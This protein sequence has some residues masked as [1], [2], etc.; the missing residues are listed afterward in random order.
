VWYHASV[1]CM[2]AV[3]SLGGG[4]LPDSACCCIQFGHTHLRQLPEVP[5]LHSA[6]TARARQPAQADP[7]EPTLHQGLGAE[8]AP[9]TETNVS[10]P[11]HASN[12]QLT[13]QKQAVILPCCLARLVPMGTSMTLFLPAQGCSRVSSLCG[14]CWY[15]VTADQWS[16]LP[17]A[18]KG[19]CLVEAYQLV[20]AACNACGADWAAVQGQ[21]RHTTFSILAAYTLCMV[22]IQQHTLLS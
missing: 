7:P 13:G 20:P 5:W 21:G 2:Y 17:H 14:C 10:M 3:C 12:V 18:V 15:C 22:S 8:P 6:S 16:H 11:C 9:Q 19:L 4:C 1:C